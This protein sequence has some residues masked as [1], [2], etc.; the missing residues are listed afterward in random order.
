[1]NDETFARVLNYPPYAIQLMAK[2][3]REELKER[4]KDGVIYPPVKETGLKLLKGFRA[5]G[6]STISI[7]MRISIQRFGQEVL[8]FSFNAYGGAV[9]WG[10]AS[11]E[12]I[13]FFE[14]PE[15]IITPTPPV[16]TIEYD[17]YLE[18]KK[19]EFFNY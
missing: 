11:H 5:W 19:Y 16:G 10:C 2:M 13:L 7:P 4:F 1:M 15:I 3:T 9:Y 12:A 8:S 18:E 17:L 14:R 6:T